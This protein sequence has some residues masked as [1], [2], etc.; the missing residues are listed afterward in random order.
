MA[1]VGLNT[2]QVQMNPSTQYNPNQRFGTSFLSS[3][4]RDY[5]VNGEAIMDKASGEL[6]MKRPIDGRVI[7]FY[8]NK[9]YINDLIMEL[10]VLLTNN[11]SFT[12]PKENESGYYV[13]TD[14]DLVAINNER[15]VNIKDHNTIIS[16]KD[17]SFSISRECNGFFIRPLTRDTDKCIVEYTTNVYNTLFESY[18]GSVTEF[19]QEHRKFDSIPFWKDSNV[20]V[21]YTVAVT[22]KDGSSASYNYTSC[23]RLNEECSIIFPIEFTSQYRE[24]VNT[25]HITITKLEYYKLHFLLENLTQID[26][27]INSNFSNEFNSEVAKFGLPDNKILVNVLNI[28]SFVDKSTDITLKGKEFLIALIDIPYVRRYMMKLTKLHNSSGFILSEAKPLEDDWNTNNIWAEPIRTLSP[29]NG[30]ITSKSSYSSFKALESYIAA[31]GI[32]YGDISDDIDLSDDFV[33]REM[34]PS[35]YI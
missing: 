35:E 13:C 24:N 4:Y 11:E 5:A 9:K 18:N 2:V 27:Y 17:V 21:Y 30:I 19:I 28:M 16:S 12:Y 32:I 14:Y 31:N 15:E 34:N 8:Q 20:M 33:F 10:R 7:S 26:S 1:D 22:T 23:V 25:I 29:Q 6:F 3:T